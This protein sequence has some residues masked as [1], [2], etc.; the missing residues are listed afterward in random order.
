M[1]SEFTA[2]IERDGEWFITFQAYALDA[3]DRKML[4]YCDSNPHPILG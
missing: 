3:T 2:V 1:P 4:W